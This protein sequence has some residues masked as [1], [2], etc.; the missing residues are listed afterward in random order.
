MSRSRKKH[1]IV[2]DRGLRRATYNRM[3]RRINRQRIK[4]GL[5]PRIMDEIINQ[6]DVCD[7][8]FYWDE[9]YWNRVFFG[10]LSHRYCYYKSMEHVKRSYFGK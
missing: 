10:D 3:F 1:G 7:Y 5:E 4:R 8:K 6:Y 2:K 9:F